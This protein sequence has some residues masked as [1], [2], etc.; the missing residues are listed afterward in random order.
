VK[1]PFNAVHLR[2]FALCFM[3]LDHLWGT[4]VSGN[5]WMTCVG[6]LA[7]PIFDFQAAEGYFHT[8]DLK[9][10]CKRL[11]VFAVISEIPLNLMLSGSWFFPF[12]QNV[13]FT[14]LL[15]ILCIHGWN[16]EK[17]RWL[18]IL[19]VLIAVV[20]FPDYGVRG[21]LT[22]AAFGILRQYPLGQLAAM[23][24]LH[25]FTVEGQMLPVGT[26]EFPVQG[27]AVLSMVLIWLYNGEK[28]S[29]SRL[30]QSFSYWFYP[31][32]MVIL[33]AIRNLAL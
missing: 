1:K 21:V 20:T 23:A 11:L 22:V 12:H 4:L 18:A 15:G 13:L 5:L 30:F 28:G 19:P 14:L 10:Y 2:V 33:W 24:V 9:R 27:F 8:S 17:R 25:I 3:L 6:R 16:Q 26:L 32:H 29:R 31:A 7:F